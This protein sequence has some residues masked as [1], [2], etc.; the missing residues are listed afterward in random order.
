M[1]KMNDTE[2]MAGDERAAGEGTTTL[3]GSLTLGIEGMTCASCVARVERAL[4]RVPGVRSA[5]VNLATE[6]AAIEYLPGEV[7]PADLKGAVE[8]AGPGIH[9]QLRG[10]EA[11]PTREVPG[12]FDTQPIARAFRDAGDQPV[13]HIAGSA[14]QSHPRDLPVMRDMRDV[15]AQAKGRSL[16]LVDAWLEDLSR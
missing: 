4:A 6:R 1:L 13:M 7:S 10:V 14:R 15:Y 9:Q 3:A 11:I 5:T 2:T 8:R 16:S 12:A